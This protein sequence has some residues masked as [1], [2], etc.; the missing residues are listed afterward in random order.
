L[1]WRIL[2]C[3]ILVLQITLRRGRVANVEPVDGTAA[4][5]C[6]EMENRAHRCRLD[7]GTNASLKIDADP[8][9]WTRSLPWPRANAD[10]LARHARRT[11]GGWRAGP[12]RWRSLVLVGL[13]GRPPHASP[14]LIRLLL[15]H[16]FRHS[17]V[18]RNRR[19]ASWFEKGKLRNRS[20]ARVFVNSPPPL[21]FFPSL[22]AF[23]SI[24]T[25]EA[26]RRRYPID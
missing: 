13:R 21:S 12:A 20:R 7:D 6:G 4:W 14:R 2:N 25:N 15:S 19:I 9:P 16:F 17:M 1:Y 23:T 26:T 3:S 8:S 5:L 11:A 24:Y 10:R 18:R 22:N